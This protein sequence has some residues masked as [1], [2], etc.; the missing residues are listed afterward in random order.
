MRKSVADILLPR[1]KEIIAIRDKSGGSKGKV[2]WSKDMDIP[3][4]EAMSAHDLGVRLEHRQ[5]MLEAL[6]PI[7]GIKRR[8]FFQPGVDLMTQREEYKH[9]AAQAEAANRKI[10]QEQAIVAGI[11]EVTEDEQ[12]MQGEE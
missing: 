11:E 4:S 5:D 3:E 1:I 10:E 12:I 8:P 9:V 7:L 2:F 6:Y